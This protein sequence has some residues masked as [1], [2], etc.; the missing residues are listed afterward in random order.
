MTVYFGDVI[1]CIVGQKGP[2][3]LGMT[4]I[5]FLQEA[6]LNADIVA[7]FSGSVL[8]GTYAAMW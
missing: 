1:L 4:V 8:T 5:R 6:R 7:L 3:R 2:G